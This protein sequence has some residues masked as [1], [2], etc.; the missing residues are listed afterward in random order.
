MCSRLG[1]IKKRLHFE[2]FKE[3]V[4]KFAEWAETVSDPEIEILGE[5]VQRNDEDWS[6]NLQYPHFLQPEIRTGRVITKM[7]K[8]KYRPMVLKGIVTKGKI[9]KDFG[10]IE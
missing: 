8:K 7:A 1:D 9:I 5:K 2:S 4:F 3:C 10:A 6:I